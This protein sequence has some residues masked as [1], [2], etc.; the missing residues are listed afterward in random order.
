MA[1]QKREGLKRRLLI[2]YVA[3]SVFLIGTILVTG[4]LPPSKEQPSFYRS[5]YEMNEVNFATQTAIA[6]NPPPTIQ[7]TPGPNHRRTPAPTIED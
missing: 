5:S 7:H 1:Q 3:V 2:I 6:T 4:L